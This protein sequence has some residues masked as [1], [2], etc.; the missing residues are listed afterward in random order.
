MNPLKFNWRYLAAAAAAAALAG[1][2]G[3]GSTVPTPPPP[4]AAQEA[5][6]SLFVTT[7]FA[8]PA[9]GTPVDVTNDVFNFDVN[10]DPTAFSALLT[11]GTY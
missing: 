1:C 2:G 4:T 7:L 10:D 6:F 3:G 11:E 8:T 9:N 5:P